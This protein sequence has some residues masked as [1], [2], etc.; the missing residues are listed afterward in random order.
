MGYTLYPEMIERR[1]A[2]AG[3]VAKIIAIPNERTGSELI[4]FV[5]DDEARGLD[6][7]RA[8]AKAALADYEVPDR[9]AVVESFPLNGNGKPDSKRLAELAASV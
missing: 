2:E 9:I 4:A 6:H 1:M 3:C 7:W 8:V 5:Q